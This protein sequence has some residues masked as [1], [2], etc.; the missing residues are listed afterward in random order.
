MRRR[1][2]GYNARTYAVQG[3]AEWSD[4]DPEV[5][6]EKKRKMRRQSETVEKQLPATKG[7]DAQPR[8]THQVLNERP[9]LQRGPPDRRVVRDPQGHTSQQ[10]NDGAVI[11]DPDGAV[12]NVG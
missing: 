12:R 2:D 3:S 10:R 1:T 9:K 8:Y 11:L 4:F 6:V 7:R 5:S